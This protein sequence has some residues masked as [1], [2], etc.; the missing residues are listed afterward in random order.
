MKSYLWP[1]FFF[2]I[3][4]D[5]W[6]ISWE[7]SMSFSTSSS[8]LTRWTIFFSSRSISVGVHFRAVGHTHCNMRVLPIQ[9]V[10]SSDRFVLGPER[11]T[12][13]T[14]TT[15][16]KLSQWILW[17]MAWTWRDRHSLLLIAI[18]FL[19]SFSLHQDISSDFSSSSDQTVYCNTQTFVK[20]Y[21]LYYY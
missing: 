10:R 9:K 7:N 12:G 16:W 21:S 18:T 1:V 13:S 5:F 20:L 17:S 6:K 15:Q 8:I 11:V 19:F 4:I 14:N 3:S 2:N